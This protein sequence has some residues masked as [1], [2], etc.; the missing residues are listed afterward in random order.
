M[1][2]NYDLKLVVD[3]DTSEAQRKLDALGE[4]ASAPGGGSGAPG[5]PSPTPAAEEAA[6][7]VKR[8]PRA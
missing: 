3:A 5:A 8:E 6:E 1:A 4:G 2:T 7:R